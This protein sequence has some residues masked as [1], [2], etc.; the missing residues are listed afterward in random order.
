MTEKEKRT[1]RRKQGQEAQETAADRARQRQQDFAVLLRRL[2]KGSPE[3]API[4]ADLAA[5]ARP[6]EW[7]AAVARIVVAALH[8]AARAE[9]KDEGPLRAVAGHLSVLIA[10]GF[11]PPVGRPASALNEQHDGMIIQAA[12]TA[13][14]PEAVAA[15]ARWD[16]GDAA[17]PLEP[18]DDRQLYNRL[19][20]R[21]GR[22]AKR[23]GI[24]L[25]PGEP[26][27]RGKP[28]PDR[29]E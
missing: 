4:V 13:T 29:S 2:E 25:Q 12:G 9:G 16:D 17:G 28:L 8:R 21:A 15:L 7:N 1:A 10:G 5:A 3:L 19:K 18:V 26:F 27:G 20:G 6:E 23:I 11:V 14:V 24:E 22:A